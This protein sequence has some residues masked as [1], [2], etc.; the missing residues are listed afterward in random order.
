[1][2]R[3]KEATAS[4]ATMASNFFTVLISMAS[5]VP[6]FGKERKQVTRSSL[7]YRF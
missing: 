3:S 5:C 4:A 2:L 6:G 7:T 1:M